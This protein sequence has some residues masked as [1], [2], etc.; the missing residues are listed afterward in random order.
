MFLKILVLALLSTT[1][2]TVGTDELE[3]D[4]QKNCDELNNAF[5]KGSHEFTK[6]VL[7]N[8]ENATFCEECVEEYANV[9]KTFNDLITSN[10]TEH[11][12]HQP[13]RDRY[14]DANQ[15]GLVETVLAHSK[16]LWMIGDCSGES[17]SNLIFR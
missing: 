7:K 14:V 5:I 4:P 16:Q 17:C 11:K 2:L 9:L 13:C 6:C 10:E 8:N 12:E 1:Y 15:L 3:K